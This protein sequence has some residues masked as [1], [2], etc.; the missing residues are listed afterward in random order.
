MARF[1]DPVELDTSFPLQDYFISSSHNTY[2]PQGQLY[3]S[4][5]AEEYVSVVSPNQTELSLA[6]P[7]RRLTSPSANP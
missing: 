6:I 5:S 1:I 7:R 4:S 3:G 2:L